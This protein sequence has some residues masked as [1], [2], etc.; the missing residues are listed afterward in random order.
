MTDSWRT[1]LEQLAPDV[2]ATFGRFPLA[3]I[4]ILL[5]TVV[6]VAAI[7]E[8]VPPSDE[9]W[10]RIV[11]GL[12]TGAVFAAA[13]KFIAESRPGTRIAALVLRFLVP[14]L[15]IAAWQVRS[16]EFLVPWALP[17]VA[18][19]FLSVSPAIRPG[20]RD[21]RRALE[22]RFWWINQRAVTTAAVAGIGLLLIALGTLAIERSLEL[23]FSLRSSDL[24]YHWVLPIAV[25]L[26]G[27]VYWLSTIPR[28]ADYAERDLTEPDFLTRA[29]GFL[30]QFILT[31]LLLI[32]ALILL[33]YGAQIL[34]TQRFPVGVLGWLVLIF[35]VTGAANWLVL[36]PEFIRN[37]PLVRLFRRSWFWLTVIPIALY[38]LAVFLRVEAFG[39]TDERLVLIAGGSWAGLLTIAFLL[40]RF[41]DIRLIPGLAALVL[42]VFSVGPWN[43]EQGPRL[44]QI[45]RLRASL[46][47]AGITGPAAAPAWS[48]EA[49]A[50]AR[51]ALAYLT[52]SEEGR[53]ML[54]GLVGELGLEPV[55]AMDLAVL[56]SRLSIPLPRDAEIPGDR[57]RLVRAPGE[58]NLAGTQVYLARLQFG[59]VEVAV[60][61]T[62]GLSLRKGDL[63][64]NSG[65]PDE[66]IVPLSVWFAGQ[67]QPISDPLIRFTYAGRGYALVVEELN[68][69]GG[70]GAEQIAYMDAT[71]FT[72]LA[73]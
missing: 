51:S 5:A 68:L 53:N 50:K 37:R 36:H 12:G 33:A 34:V 40:P 15:A 6:F 64:V 42:L 44:D 57:N 72:A 28:L 32:Y 20:K 70:A 11:A 29:I 41:A 1:R 60:N 73:P 45:G 59:E 2:N 55:A 22:D 17:A 63:V 16:T 18:L 7:N 30:G 19:L 35:V 8:F 25:I 66:A 9:L 38:G 24:F 71:L 62:L 31:P 48:E 4:L 46:A 21:E 52:H 56:M 3:V 61:D 65:R 49:A 23:L 26:L 14:V 54:S 58:V 47:T 13:G 67:R 10:W 27:P 43:F 69:I 39:L